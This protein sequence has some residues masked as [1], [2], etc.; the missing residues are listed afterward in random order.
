M[1]MGRPR[2]DAERLV[3]AGAGA[4][5]QLGLGARFYAAG[6]R[7]ARPQRQHGS[8][9]RA[10]H[11][12]RIRAVAV[13]AA[14]RRP[15]APGCI[16]SRPRWSSR[17]C[18]WA[19][20]W[21]RAPSAPARRSARCAAPGACCA[22]ARSCSCRCCAQCGRCG[23]VRPGERLPVDGVVTAGHSALDESLIT[24]ES[25]PVPKGPGDAVTGGSSTARACW[26]C[27]AARWAR[28]R[29]AGI[30]RLVEQAQAP[31]R[32]YNGWW[33]RSPRCS[34]P[35]WSPSAHSRCWAGACGRATGAGLLM[36]WRCW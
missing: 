21:R 8:A 9:G 26:C 27:A 28:S 5:V 36:R 13:R 4:P 14:D 16:S 30:I 2:R 6:W 22:A 3:A 1:L 17:W 31:R 12:G 25:L 35:R 18:C 11:L 34:C 29:G 10:G 7:A 15:H 33:T 20:G 19:S 23:A 32:R 24:G